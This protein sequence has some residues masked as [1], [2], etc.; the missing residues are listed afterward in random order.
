METWGSAA[1]CI[2]QQALDG[3]RFSPWSHEQLLSIGGLLADFPCVG[4]ETLVSAFPPIK[5]TVG[6]QQQ[7]LLEYLLLLFLA[8]KASSRSCSQRDVQIMAMPDMSRS[9]PVFFEACCTMLSTSS[10]AVQCWRISL[11]IYTARKAT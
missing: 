1:E 5:S 2:Q 6:Q 11:F 7:Q 8:M 9:G 3:A 10:P 4:L